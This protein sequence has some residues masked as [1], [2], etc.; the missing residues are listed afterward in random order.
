VGV[1]EGF[2]LFIKLLLFHLL[3]PFSGN[4]GWKVVSQHKM[5]SGKE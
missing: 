4:I 1:A 5:H 2:L 3:I